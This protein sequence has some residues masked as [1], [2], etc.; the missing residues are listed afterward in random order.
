MGG[1]QEGTKWD[2]QLLLLLQ[3]AG[4]LLEDSQLLLSVLELP[5]GP[6]Q[7]PCQLLVG[8]LQ[9]GIFS[10]GLVLVIMQGCALA[11]QLERN[12]EAEGSDKPP[13]SESH[14]PRPL[15]ASLAGQT[16][17]IPAPSP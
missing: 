1:R 16:G 2:S 9:L 10:P 14:P 17:T 8:E 7:L 15:F 4:L 3:L 5:G 13:S 11:F 12:G 6:L